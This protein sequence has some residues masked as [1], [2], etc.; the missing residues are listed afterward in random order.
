METRSSFSYPS[1]ISFLQQQQR[2]RTIQTALL[3]LAI[4]R[5]NSCSKGPFILSVDLS[6]DITF[7]D[8]RLFYKVSY[9]HVDDSVS[10]NNF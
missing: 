3:P 9:T 2:A 8:S 1:L 6:Y 7:V 4:D 5:L 10:V